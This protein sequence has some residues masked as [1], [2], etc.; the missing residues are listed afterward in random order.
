MEEKIKEKLTAAF[1][2]EKLIL[3]NQSHLHA[4]HFA[5]EKAEEEKRAHTHF[6]IL[7]VSAKFTSLAKVARHRWVYQVLQDELR[8]DVHALS[9]AAYSPEEYK[10]DEDSFA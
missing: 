8:G 3:V 1:S 6:K 5:M 10:K 7:I 9:V 2:P 4:H